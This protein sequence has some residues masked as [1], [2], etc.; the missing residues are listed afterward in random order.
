MSK[1]KIK[2]WMY[3]S[4]YMHLIADNY[5]IYLRDLGNKSR[6]LYFH[7]LKHFWLDFALILID[8][9]SHKRHHFQHFI[10]SRVPRESLEK[11]FLK[12]LEGKDVSFWNLS[13]NNILP[14]KEDLTHLFLVLK[15]ISQLQVTLHYSI[16][17]KWAV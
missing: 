12:T 16:E 9:W 8:P 3:N 5:T 13:Y 7:P 11:C 14:I 10:S 1:I 17:S 4:D 6:A 15:S 2:I